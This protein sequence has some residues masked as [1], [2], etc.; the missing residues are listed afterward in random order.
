MFV[1]D[2]KI[3]I[4]SLQPDNDDADRE[5][6]VLFRSNVSVNLQPA[7]ADWQ[8]LATGKFGRAWEAYLPIT[9]SGI[10]SSMRVIVTSPTTVSGRKYQVEGVEV[11]DTLQL[12]HYR[13]LLVEPNE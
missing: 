8:A 12:G 13:I 4:Y 2:K 11:W 3:D 1:S 10:D 7:G 5:G 6:Y 9:Q